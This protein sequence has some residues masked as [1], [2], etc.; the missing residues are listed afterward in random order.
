MNGGTVPNTCTQLTVGRGTHAA[1]KHQ[2]ITAV[3]G[4]PWHHGR[5]QQVN[6][7][8]ASNKVVQHCTFPTTPPP[9]PTCRS[10]VSAVTAPRRA[11]PE[12]SRAPSLLPAAATSASRCCACCCT[13]ADS[14]ATWWAADSA[15]CQWL[16]RCRSGQHPQWPGR[17]IAVLCWK[18]V[19]Q[20]TVQLLQL[21]PCTSALLLL[22]AWYATTPTVWGSQLSAALPSPP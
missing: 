2:T 9:P 8:A 16:M 13:L 4:W 14:S 12:P 3:W 11:A 15:S 7:H 17:D 10:L 18:M 1:G 19:T 22:Q 20:L 6:P 5:V 21:Q